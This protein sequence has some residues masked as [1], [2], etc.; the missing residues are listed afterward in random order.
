MIRY[1]W[2][3]RGSCVTGRELARRLGCCR[4]MV[5]PRLLDSQDLVLCWGGRLRG[6]R[7]GVVEKTFND[8]ERV[9]CYSNKYNALKVMEDAGVRVPKSVLGSQLVEA[10]EC[11]DLELPVVRR[12]W[13]HQQGLD[14]VLVEDDPQNFDNGY[15]LQFIPS[16]REYRVHVFDG[17]VIRASKKV[18]PRGL[19][20]DGG[21][22]RCHHGGWIM[23]DFRSLDNLGQRFKDV[24]VAAVVAL[25]YVFGAVDVVV[26]SEDGLPYVLEVNS[27]PSLDERGLS[28]YVE[29]VLRYVEVWDVE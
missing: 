19:D 12:R 26:S 29:N 6:S 5:S 7:C 23:R 22:V 8:V 10:L 13:C 2:Y 1:V 20:G 21:W 15:V 28:V 14:A 9:E 27:A 17:K 25:G 3:S 16:D 4:T 24:A 18:F 11:G